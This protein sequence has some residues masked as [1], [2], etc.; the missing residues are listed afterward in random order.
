M[1]G[2]PNKAWMRTMTDELGSREAVSEHMRT[3]GA[4]GGKAGRTGGFAAKA[5]CLCAEIPG[6]HTKPQC[7]GMRGGRISRRG[8]RKLEQA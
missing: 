1:S 2:R 4:K 6:Q 7:A 8:S 5:I 3:I